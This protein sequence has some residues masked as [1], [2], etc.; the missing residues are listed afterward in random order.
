MKL[1][2]KLFGRFDPEADTPLEALKGAKVPVIF[3]HGESDDMVPC[4]MSKACFDACA[5]RKHLVTVPGAGHGLS[6]AMDP[7]GYLK[8]LGDFFGPEASYSK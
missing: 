1:G 4:C 8:E 2:A 5:S 3:F 6:Y 7:E